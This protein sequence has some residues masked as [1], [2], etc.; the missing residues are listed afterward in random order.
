MLKT[1]GS[2]GS[3]VDPEETESKAGGN[4]VVGN[5][6]VD[7]SE[8]TN[9]VNSTKRKNQVKTTKSKI[10]VK[11]KNHDFPPNSK[12]KKAGTEFLTPKARLVFTQL[13]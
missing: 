1:T 7:D 3:T 6:V 9:Q 2:T 12:N 11:S 4:S 10:L 8:V 13:K 5:S